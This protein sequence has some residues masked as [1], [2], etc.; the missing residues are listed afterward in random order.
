MA[1][2]IFFILGVKNQISTISLIKTCCR[3]FET[4]RCSKVPVGSGTGYGIKTLALDPNF[5][6]V[7]YQVDLDP[8]L[9]VKCDII[10]F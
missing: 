2:R 4:I 7:P 8:D 6:T 9:H 1:L 5:R 10:T 3:L